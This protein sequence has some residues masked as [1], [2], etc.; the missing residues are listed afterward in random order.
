LALFLL[1]AL[2]GMSYFESP[3]I[4]KSA[5]EFEKQ[6]EIKKIYNYSDSYLE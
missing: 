5:L 6:P 2:I 4:D 1:I 3:I